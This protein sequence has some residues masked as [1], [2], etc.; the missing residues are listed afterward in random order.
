VIPT[1]TFGNATIT[2]TSG[3]VSAQMSVSV[4]C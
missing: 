3:T 1:R 2:A 4:T